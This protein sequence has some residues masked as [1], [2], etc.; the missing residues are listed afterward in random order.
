MNKKIYLPFATHTIFITLNDD[1]IYRLNEDFSKIEV[2]EL[3]QSSR[4]N[5][6]MVLHKEQFKMA[7][8]ERLSLEDVKIYN[9][10][11]FL[12][13]EELAAFIN[14][15]SSDISLLKEKAK[16]AIAEK[17]Y[18]KAYKLLGKA[19]KLKKY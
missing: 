18:P 9:K 2:N 6:I 12:T 16:K 15:D 17:N 7:N 11:G 5:P 8:T 3:P 1:K 4:Q 10:I 13:D 14:I 19:K